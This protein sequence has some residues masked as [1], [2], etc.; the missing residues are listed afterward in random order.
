MNIINVTL[1]NFITMTIF[2]SARIQI[3]DPE[4][5]WNDWIALGSLAKVRRKYEHDGIVSP[6]TRSAPN[7]SAIQKAAFKY[8]LQNP[9]VA[10]QRF[11]HECIKNGTPPTEEMWKERWYRIGRLLYYQRPNRLKSFIEQYG[12]EKYADIN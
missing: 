12:L 7:E 10:K 3:L 1:Y 11:E 4:S 2:I 6:R 9:D 8:A 5:C